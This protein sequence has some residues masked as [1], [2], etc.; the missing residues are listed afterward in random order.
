LPIILMKRDGLASRGQNI[1]TM[2][3]PISRQKDGPAWERKVSSSEFIIATHDG[4]HPSSEYRDW[5]FSTF[6]RN[7]HAMYFERWMRNEEDEEYWYL[8]RAYFSIYQ[9]IDWNEEQEFLCLHCDPNIQL[10]A[11]EPVD[12]HEKMRNRASP[13]S[14]KKGLKS[15][16]NN[17]SNNKIDK[18]D[19][20]NRAKYKKGP[21]LHI[22]AAEDPLPH[23]HFAL[24][25]G[26]LDAVLDSVESLTEAM[27]F[28]ILMLKEEVLDR[29]APQ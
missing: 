21:H 13:R 11:E 2:L 14:N 5:R 12:T 4:S 16:K 24:N 27:R 28:G 20:P 26:H 15:K 1:R 25:L 8:E 18:L 29:C 10:E 7:F 9:R 17:Q 6:V 19:S 3:Q 22:K 23:A